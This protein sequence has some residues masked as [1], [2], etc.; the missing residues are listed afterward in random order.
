M[1]TKTPD[2]CYV[3]TNGITRPSLGRK[4]VIGTVAP[5]VSAGSLQTR[6]SLLAVAVAIFI[7]CGLLFALSGL[8]TK[9]AA[10][11]TPQVGEVWAWGYNE[12]GLLGDGTTT[13]RST[14][15]R[16]S[17]LTNVTDVAAGSV[18]SLA[19][20]EA[21]TA[22][23]V[24]KATPTGRKVSR[25]ANVTATFSEKMRPSRRRIPP[26]ASPPPSR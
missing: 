9:P 17:G 2:R 10:A 6:R 12:S 15:V 25:G 7:A 11:Q 16:V 18:Y 1:A 8:A 22:P 5:K 13:N 23:R 20:T 21:T 24:T 4:K 3:W 14:P 19:V 26:P